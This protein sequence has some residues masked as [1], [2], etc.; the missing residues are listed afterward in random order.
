M[1]DFLILL[2]DT[3]VVLALL[4]GAAIIFAVGK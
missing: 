2:G 4:A 1:R 3:V